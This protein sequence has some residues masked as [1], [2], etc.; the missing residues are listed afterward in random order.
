MPSSAQVYV[1]DEN[2]FFTRATGLVEDGVNYYVRTS[3]VEC[4]PLIVSGTYA[5]SSFKMEAEVTLD[6][7]VL[8]AKSGCDS[9]AMRA[10]INAVVE[11]WFDF[12]ERDTVLLTD[13]LNLPS[14]II[15]YSYTSISRYDASIF[16]IRRS[17][18]N[19]TDCTTTL[20]TLVNKA[21][22]NFMQTVYVEQKCVSA[23]RQARTLNLDRDAVYM[24]PT[25]SKY[26]S[27]TAYYTVEKATMEDFVSGPVYEQDENSYYYETRDTDYDRT[28][29]Y[30]HFVKMDSDERYLTVNVQAGASNLTVLNVFAG[31]D[32]PENS[33]YEYNKTSGR[34]ELTSDTIFAPEKNYYYY[35]DSIT[36]NG[37]LLTES[38]YEATTELVFG[39]SKYYRFVEV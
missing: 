28:K 29:Y 15:N 39:N 14:Y 19:G 26:K 38:V 22:D 4:S 12:T 11:R 8:T 24:L 3:S 25:E 17:L 30:Y 33:Y 18:V 21:I 7:Y 34:Y 31:S 6:G 9:R 1:L 27:Y 37:A 13:F 35:G 20:T 10:A 5:A 2:G 32:I 23:I 36:L 16:T